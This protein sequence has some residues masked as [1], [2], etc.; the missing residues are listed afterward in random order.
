MRNTH[1]IKHQK[2]KKK[3]FKMEHPAC[4]VASILQGF[5]TPK[6][7]ANISVVDKSFHKKIKVPPKEKVCVKCDVVLVPFECEGGYP[8]GTCGNCVGEYVQDECTCGY[9]YPFCKGCALVEQFDPYDEGG[10]GEIMFYFCP[11]C[12][13]SNYDGSMNDDDIME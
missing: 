3:D 2:L 9:V 13:I 11:N 5:L 12:P 8:E 4:Q 10:C 1:A 7:R 6:E